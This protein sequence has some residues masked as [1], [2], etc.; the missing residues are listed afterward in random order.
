MKKF[1]LAASLLHAPAA[2]SFAQPPIPPP[3]S[4]TPP[5]PAPEKAGAMNISPGL[6]REG[7]KDAIVAALA[8]RGWQVV[9]STRSEVRGHMLH[10]KKDANLIFQFDA[11]HIDILSDSYVVDGA[12][13]RTARIIPNDWIENLEQ[14]IREFAAH[15]PQK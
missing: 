12:G 7:V 13:V 2:L 6:S 4:D 11:A 9:S 14:D 1:L 10:H 5:P 3:P 15:M 8:K